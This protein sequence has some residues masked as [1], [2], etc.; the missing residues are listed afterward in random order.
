MIPR[1]S[2]LGQRFAAGTGI[3]TLMKD[4]GQALAAGGDV[5][6][7]GGGQP[8]SIPAVEAVWRRRLE[9]ILAE[10]GAMER[11]LGH[12][13]PPRGN[14]RFVE[15]VAGLLRSSF[16][17]DV[18]PEHV[19]VTVGGQTAFFMLFNLLAGRMADGSRRE[20]L[21]PLVPEYIG[22]AS[23]GLD[24]AV[25][26]AV[27]PRIERIGRHDFKYHVDFEALE[28]T[29][30]TAAI[31]VSRPTNP[32]GN[33]LTD[34]E[35]AR[36]SALARQHGIPLIIDNAYGAPFPGA[37]FTPAEPL[38]GD[39]VILTLSLSKL[40][41]PGTRTGIVVG[42]PEVVAAVAEMGSVI[43]LA[44]PNIGQE[45]V[46]PLVASGEILRLSETVIRPF[47]EE[48]SR[49]ARGWVEEAFGDR[50][51]YAVHLSEGA[52][53]FW[54]WFPG[55][56]ATTQQLYERLKARGVLVVPGHHFFYGLDVPDWP[57]PHECIRLTFTMPPETVREGLAII[58]EE[59]RR[60][61]GAKPHATQPPR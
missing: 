51:D 10:P 18:T 2:A 39:H 38:W 31:C 23:Q 17:W 15:A 21:L 56:P 16:G 35:L 24:N 22:Y 32:T 53:F 30:E 14:P 3:G 50:F 49:L 54:V 7:L 57:H 37:I 11:M 5:K 59:V 19:A 13:D 4:L 44:N 60:L 20:I 12:Y 1:F 9:E 46:L 6:M 43:G 40:G 29:A 8:A 41:L 52:F 48:R 34:D 25:F 58:G 55:L 61:H 33:V 36:L 45:I 42:P 27:P 28:V 47:Y 26:R